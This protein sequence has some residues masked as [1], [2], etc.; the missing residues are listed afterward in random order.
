LCVRG[1][2]PS[3][4]VIFFFISFSCKIDACGCVT[5]G[6]SRRYYL[7]FSWLT[8]AINLTL[9]LSRRNF[10]AQSCH[11]EKSIAS[12][13]VKNL[14]SPMFMSFPTDRSTV[15][16]YP[17]EPSSSPWSGFRFNT[18]EVGR[19]DSEFQGNNRLFASHIR[20]RMVKKVSSSYRRSPLDLQIK[21]NWI[22][23]GTT[24]NRTTKMLA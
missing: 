16:V 12:S 20:H 6:V 8:L 1:R 5:Q 13:A 18:S 24:K 14:A 4:K 10:S 15:R 3:A 11:P 7:R 9:Y 22:K 2:G 19:F 23:T 21:Q 17:G